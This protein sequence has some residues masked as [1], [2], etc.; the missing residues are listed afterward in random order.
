LKISRR[1]PHNNGLILGFEGIDTPEEAGK[2]RATLAYVETAG[3]PALPE[4]EYYHHQI[5]GLDVVDETGR[6][7]GR[8]TEIIETGANDV[9]VVHPAQGSDILLPALKEV[10]LGVD[11]ENKRMRV[12]LLPGLIDSDEEHTG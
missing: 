7:L 9:Y 10:I 8:L 2:L 4:G 3:R 5:I 6:E 11:L 1:R 12:H